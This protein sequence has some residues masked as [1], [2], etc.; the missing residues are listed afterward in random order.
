MFAALS[1]FPRHLT[2][3][4][5]LGAN[6]RSGVLH[7]R[8]SSSLSNSRIPDVAEVSKRRQAH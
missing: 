8:C 7:D 1:E 4:E 2:A 6:K 3:A 5:N